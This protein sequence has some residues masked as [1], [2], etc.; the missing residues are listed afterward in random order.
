[1]LEEVDLQWEYIK[2]LSAVSTVGLEL[3]VGAPRKPAPYSCHIGKNQCK[4]LLL[5][6]CE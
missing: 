3:T 1:M 4:A 5:S 6:C 2:I